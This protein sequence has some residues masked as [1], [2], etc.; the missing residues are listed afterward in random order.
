[1]VFRFPQLFTLKPPLI[2]HFPTHAP[3]KRRFAIAMLDD[4]R[5]YQLQ[6][7]PKGLPCPQFFE[8]RAFFMDT[9]LKHQWESVHIM[10]QCDARNAAFEYENI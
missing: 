9:S 4:T 1:M 6:R 5:G 8:P 7:S 2:D 3:F 10:W